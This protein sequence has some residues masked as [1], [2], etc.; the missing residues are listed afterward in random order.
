MDVE[1]FPDMVAVTLK[2]DDLVRPG[3]PHQSRRVRPAWPFAKDLHVAANEPLARSPRGCVDN[4]QKIMVA[5]LFDTL[6][7]LSWHRSGLRSASRRITKNEGVIELDVF[8][9]F[10]RPLVIGL[11]FTRE[12]D[13]HVSSQSYAWS[14]LSN[15]IYEGEIF[16]RSVRPMHRLQ[17]SIG[18]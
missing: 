16:L 13:D 1:D 17:D 9:Q 10:P 6:I 2:N 4:R 14:A 3:A 15:A 7:N 8:N 18:T 12:T 5:L 11:I